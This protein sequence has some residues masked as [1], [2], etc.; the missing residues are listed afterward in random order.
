MASLLI[1][2]NCSICALRPILRVETYIDECDAKQLNVTFG[3][4]DPRESMLTVDDPA[5]V[6]IGGKQQLVPVGLVLGARVQCDQH[7]V[8]NRIVPVHVL[9]DRPD[10]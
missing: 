1:I 7:R 9:A 6:S 10:A 4:A 3:L 8:G 5:G 2:T